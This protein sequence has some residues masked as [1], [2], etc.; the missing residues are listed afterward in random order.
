MASQG[1]ARV[2][3]VR[4]VAIVGEFASGKTTLAD[5]LVDHHG[6]TRVSFAARLKE[7]AAAVYN[8]GQPIEKNNLYTVS[9][10]GDPNYSVSGRE[11]LQQLGQA[12]KALDENFWIRWLLADLGAEGRTGFVRPGTYVSDDTRFP[13]EADALRDQGFAII[14]LNTPRDVRMDRY[15]QLY[16]R[17]PNQS[18]LN[19]P[20]EVESRLIQADM[21]LDGTKPVEE[22]AAAI[23]STGS[24]LAA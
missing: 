14:R 3:P 20:S 1:G 18:E 8:G 2:T 17:R 13:Y 22:L 16:G 15:E 21:T 6:Y 4:S 23:I 11:L 7:V 24:L 5:Y 10:A 12:V 19:H 9:R